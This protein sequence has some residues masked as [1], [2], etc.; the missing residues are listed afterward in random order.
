MI[1]ANKMDLAIDD[2]VA[3]EA[4]Q[5]AAGGREIFAISGGTRMGIEPLLEELCACSKSPDAIESPA[6]KRSTLG[7]EVVR[8]A[9]RLRE[10]SCPK[11][12][13]TGHYRLR[14]CKS[15][16]DCLVR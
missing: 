11:R 1:A 6:A 8:V 9:A 16:C 14:G 7:G 12:V 2:D 10:P 4:D 3:R 5:R 15:C 13:F